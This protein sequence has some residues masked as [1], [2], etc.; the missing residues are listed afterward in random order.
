LAYSTPTDFDITLRFFLSRDAL[1]A[2]SSPV[3]R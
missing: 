2:R 1:L 3:S